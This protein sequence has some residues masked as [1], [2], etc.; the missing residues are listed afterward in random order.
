MSRKRVIY[1]SEALFTTA[2]A[3]H[4]NLDAADQLLRVQDISHGVELDKQ[5]VNEFGQLEAV[6][7]KV[8]NP[9]T[10]S[11]D[12]SYYLHGGRNERLLNFAMTTDRESLNPDSLE[13]A[14][15]NFLTDDE[16]QN[17]YISVAGEGEDAKDKSGSEIKGVIG[18]GN[19]YITSYSVEAAVGDMPSASVSV[20][21]SNI[22]FSATGEN[23]SNPAF[24][25]ATGEPY[26]P[27]NNNTITSFPAAADTG[28]KDEVSDWEYACL[29]PGD[30]IV[31]FNDD[32]NC[33]PSS[34][35]EDSTSIG[36][37]KLEGDGQCHLQNFTLDVPLSREALTRLGNVHPYS[38][39]VETPINITLSVSA[40]LGDIAEGNLNNILCDTN[41]RNIRIKMLE[42]CPEGGTRRIAQE[43]LLKGASLDSQNFTASIG[44]N[45]SVDLVFTAQ[46]GGAN[47]KTAGLFMW[48]SVGAGATEGTG[49]TG[50]DFSETTG[51]IEN[52]IGE[53]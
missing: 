18:I 17:Y 53:E 50:F 44:D 27:D 49:A 43:F 3:N 25:L 37:A 31:D 7:R 28:T 36:G 42:P 32:G 13:N 9:P 11:L 33:F 23:V 39:E 5:D 4:Q 21:A 12:F 14:I 20:E 24:N 45:K 46:S 48:S 26:D 41:T 47:S 1:Q 35:E 15:Q 52:P 51:A 2:I 29:R 22:E 10:V 16:G 34:S 19:G 38:R 8:I 6:E 40:F 30:V